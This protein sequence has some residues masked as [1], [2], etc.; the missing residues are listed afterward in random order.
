[1]K[2]NEIEKCIEVFENT[3]LTKNK[4]DYSSVFTG[5][6]CLAFMK[7]E[8]SQNISFEN[9]FGSIKYLDIEYA[10]T[11]WIHLTPLLRQTFF[12]G[13]ETQRYVALSIKKCI[14]I[15][16]KLTDKGER[17]YLDGLYNCV[18]ALHQYC[19]GIKKAGKKETDELK[20]CVQKAKN[21]KN[22]EIANIWSC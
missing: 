22:Y 16:E 11:L 13:E 15:Y 5:I 10:K 14:D 12:Q 8:D 2:K 1:M 21:I 3:I 19:K 18:E 9:F 6:H 7:G 4:K 20:E 17:Y